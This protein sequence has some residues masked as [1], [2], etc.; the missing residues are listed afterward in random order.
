M[1]LSI[2]RS[3]DLSH[4]T[5]PRVAQELRRTP[6]ILVTTRTPKSHKAKAPYSWAMVGHLA[7]LSEAGQVGHLFGKVTLAVTFQSMNALL[8]VSANTDRLVG[9]LAV[10]T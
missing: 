5:P 10:D 8:K 3:S 7:R 1:G 6:I 4:I 9:E 2:P